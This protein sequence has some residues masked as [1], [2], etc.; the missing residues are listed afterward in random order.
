MTRAVMLRW[1]SDKLTAVGIL[2]VATSFQ[3]PV[4][5]C[6]A[7]SWIAICPRAAPNHP[8]CYSLPHLDYFAATSVRYHS[9]LRPHQ[10]LENV[11]SA[12]IGRAPPGSEGSIRPEHLSRGMLSHHERKDA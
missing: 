11:P 1:P 8:F 6:L 7:E 12:G 2:T 4:A 3:A 5:N 9:R 10:S